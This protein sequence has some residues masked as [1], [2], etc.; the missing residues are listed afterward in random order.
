M[1]SHPDDKQ[2]EIDQNTA[3]PLLLTPLQAAKVLSIGRTTL[4]G[5]LASGAL[6]SVQIGTSRRITYLALQD[7][8]GGL[9]TDPPRPTTRSRGGHH[10]VAGALNRPSRIQDNTRASAGPSKMGG[11]RSQPRPTRVEAP[12]L[13]FTEPLTGPPGP[14]HCEES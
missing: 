9:R 4:Y 3:G 11:T 1:R 6:A 2:P 14:E 12:S 13:P 7:Y 8:V 10:P 5:L